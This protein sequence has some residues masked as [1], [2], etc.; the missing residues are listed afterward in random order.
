MMEQTK[1]E[2]TVTVIYKDDPDAIPIT[3][4]FYDFN[5]AKDF[6]YSLSEENV[7]IYFVATEYPLH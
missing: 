2:Y 7:N 1:I 4:Y 6:A 5:E 3:L